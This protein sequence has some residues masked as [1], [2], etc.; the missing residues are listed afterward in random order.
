MRMNTSSGTS[1][2]CILAS[3][4]PSNKNACAQLLLCPTPSHLLPHFIHGSGRQVG[5]IEVESIDFHPSYIPDSVPTF[6]LLVECELTKNQQLLEHGHVQ[7]HPQSLSILFM[8]VSRVSNGLSKS[9]IEKS[10]A[11]FYFRLYTCQVQSRQLWFQG[12]KHHPLWSSCKRKRT[13]RQNQMKI[14]MKVNK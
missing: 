9:W 5:S 6:N 4:S 12:R 13:I 1:I 7:I 8:C 3:Y 11:A 2:P 10:A 14:E